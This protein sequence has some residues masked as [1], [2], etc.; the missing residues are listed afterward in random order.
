MKIIAS[1]NLKGGVGKTSLIFGIAGFLSANGTRV[2]VCDFDAQSNT[3]SSMGFDITQPKYPSMVDVFEDNRNPEEIII[4]APIPQLPLL[5]LMPGSILLTRTEVR[6]INYPA[7]EMIFKNYLKKYEE[8]FS[9]YD[10]ILCDLNP[11]VNI[12]NINALSAATSVLIPCDVSMHGLTGATLLY[13]LWDDISKSLGIENNIKGFIINRYD[14]RIKLSGEFLDFC[15]END[16]IK[17]ILFDTIIPENIKIKETE[18]EHVPIN[19]YDTKC[20]GFEAYKNLFMELMDK[21]VV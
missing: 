15:K 2:C 11:S 10:V 14:K 4:K 12:L 16:I 6:I 9:E 18:I 17:D 20:V 13:S 1:A 19:L 3:T 5:D 21:E 7:R 8:F